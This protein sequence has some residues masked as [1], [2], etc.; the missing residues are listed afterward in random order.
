MALTQSCSRAH[1]TA[2]QIA[3]LKAMGRVNQESKENNTMN[4]VLN[5]TRRTNYIIN[6]NTDTSESRHTLK[7]SL[8]YKETKRKGHVTCEDSA[9]DIWASLK[10]STSSTRKK[11]PFHCLHMLLIQQHEN[12]VTWWMAF[13]SFWTK[14]LMEHCLLLLFVDQNNELCPQSS[15]SDDGLT[16]SSKNVQ[17]YKWI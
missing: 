2:V 15:Q 11:K 13:V 1:L 7:Y 5:L 14:K 10:G 4:Y 9:D 6:H 8:A 16:Y 3:R 17:Y 12:N